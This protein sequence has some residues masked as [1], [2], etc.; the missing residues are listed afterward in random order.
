MAIFSKPEK[1]NSELIV[2]WE[3]RGLNI[4]DKKY[5]EH[6]LDFISYYRLSAYTIP[7]Q[8][9]TAKTHQ[10]KENTYFD[11]ILNLY[12]FDRELRLLIMDA[13][14]RIE[15]AVRAQ[16]C[17]VFSLA[18]D[19]NN[20]TFGAFWYL[21]GK[22]FLHKFPHF[23]FL[24]KL[25]KQLLEEKER[26]ERDINHI[27]KRNIPEEQKQTLIANTKKENFLRHYLSQYDEPRLPPC[28][29]MIEMLTWGE[30]SHLYANL[31][32]SVLKKQVAKNL[33]L[34]AEILESW[35]KVFNSIRN[36]CAHHSRLWNREL[37][38]AIKIPQSAQIKWLS[39]EPSRSQLKN[40]QYG[41]RIYSILIALQ[42]ILYTVNPKSSWAKRL[43][44][45]MDKYPNISLSNMGMPI[46]WYEDIFWQDALN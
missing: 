39:K 24:A 13:I 6:Y 41:R 29:M 23:R 16:I 14:E 3:N 45:L 34:N 19:E 30:L 18:K 15:V 9:S 7:F 27:S 26:L 37:G 40:I 4:P 36:F 46:D 35:L 12:I 1:T 11:D 2:E 42:S 38:V 8:I 31:Q 21:D 5:A 22:H 43:K 20:N 28:W 44:E 32:S 17:N 33:G 10:F 25:E